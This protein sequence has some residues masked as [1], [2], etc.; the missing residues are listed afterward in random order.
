MLSQ[1]YIKEDMRALGDVLNLVYTYQEVAALRMRKVKLSVLGNREYLAGLNEILSRVEYSY[2]KE[3]EVLRLRSRNKKKDLKSVS[4]LP[5]NGKSVSVFLSANTGLYGD[6]IRNVF[7][8]FL[9]YVKGHDTDI[10]VVGK[11]GKKF[12]DA[13]NL[14]KK[15]TYFDYSDGGSDFE[16]AKNILKFILNYENIIVFHGIFRNIV[17]QEPTSVTISGEN[18]RLSAKSDINQFL[19]IFE[20]SIEEIVTFFEA[21]VLSSI[22]EQAMYES[23]LSK[24]ASRLINL[25]SAVVNVSKRIKKTQFMFQQLRHRKFNASQSNVISGISLWS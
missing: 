9:E 21:Q 18:I 6:I 1:K 17:V 19:C 24:F 4:I 14:N 2:R 15:Y 16:A 13:H 5:N 22:F 25:D 23:A 3:M 11:L 20:P 8:S 12:L 7:N 10:V